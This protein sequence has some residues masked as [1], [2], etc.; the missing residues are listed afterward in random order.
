VTKNPSNEEHN[1]E[2]RLSANNVNWVENLIVLWKWKY[3]VIIATLLPTL[4]AGLIFTILLKNYKVFYTYD[5]ELGARDFS[6]I[7]NAFY[8]AKNLGKL[9]EK[10]NQ[11]E[12]KTYKDKLLQAGRIGKIKK[13]I[14]FEIQPSY[15]MSLI[16]SDNVNVRDL[17][18]VQQEKGTSLTIHI[19]A[20]SAKGLTE[21]SLICKENFEQIIPLYLEKK[22]LID[23]ICNFKTKLADIENER[24]PLSLKLEA[25]KAALEKFKKNTYEITDKLPSEIIVQFNNPDNMQYLP[26]PYQIQA[27]ETQVINLE[28][29]V[30][31][32]NDEYKHYTTLLKVTEDIYNKI[33]DLMASNGTFLQLHSFLIDALTKYD[34]N[35]QR[36]YL[37]SYI[38][39][40]EN[41]IMITA[42]LSEQPEVYSVSNGAVKKTAIVCILSLILSIFTSFLLES[43]PQKATD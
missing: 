1:K 3:F 19:E 11:E 18:S 39:R 5:I 32:N 14:H 20:K 12:L 9:T 7:E 31:I 40:V 23:T 24:Y 25:E 42:P 34:E 36:D 27:A 41:K 17:N 33:S 10:M 43:F 35:N 2:F 38:K 22:Y 21:I 30:E 37:S 13:Y 28:K 15:I 8:S 16:S 29:Q 6:I 26:L 4:I